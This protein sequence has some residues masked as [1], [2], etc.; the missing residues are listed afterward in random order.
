MKVA[1][2]GYSGRAIKQWLDT[3]G[4]T[5]KN[6]KPMYMSVIYKILNNSF[7]YGVFEFGGKIYQGKH[8]PLITK[9][10]FDAVQQHML[11][12]PREWHKKTFA[13]K[14]ICRWFLRGLCDR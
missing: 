1:K 13:F 12:P 6:G 8:E 7:Y 9:A 2:Q 11:V 14:T 4:F 5:A 10:I 3:I